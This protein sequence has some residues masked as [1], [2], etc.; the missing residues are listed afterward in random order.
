MYPFTPICLVRRLLSRLEFEDAGECDTIHY[1]NNIEF[2]GRDLG[3]PRDFVVL[4]LG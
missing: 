3:E 4:G 2:L 1:G